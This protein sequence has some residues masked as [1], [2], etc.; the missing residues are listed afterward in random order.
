MIFFDVENSIFK[1]EKGEKENTKELH[2]YG[3]KSVKDKVEKY[4]GMIEW[5]E[6]ENRFSVV[7]TFLSTQRKERK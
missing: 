7:V 3:L 2:G 1:G 5:G 4:D 6:K